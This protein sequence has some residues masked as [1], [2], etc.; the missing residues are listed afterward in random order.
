MTT[1]LRVTVRDEA[2]ITASLPGTLFTV[3]ASRPTDLV[4]TNIVD[5][6]RVALTKPDLLVRALRVAE[7]QARMLGWIG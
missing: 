2:T 6:R 5:D 1:G 3:K 4:A 7:N